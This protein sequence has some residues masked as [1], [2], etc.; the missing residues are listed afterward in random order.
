MSLLIN[1]VHM[2]KIHGWSRYMCEIWGMVESFRWN[3]I[4]I[5]GNLKFVDLYFLASKL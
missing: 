3:V 5:I 2:V 1:I 4:A